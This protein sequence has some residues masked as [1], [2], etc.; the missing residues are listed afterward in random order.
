M[1][2]TA[3]TGMMTICR[4]AF[5]AITAVRMTENEP[6]DFIPLVRVVASLH[7][8]EIEAHERGAC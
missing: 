2:R 1:G 5:A 6:R 3:T 4:A 7:T 8:G